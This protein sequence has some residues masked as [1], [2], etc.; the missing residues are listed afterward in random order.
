MVSLRMAMV[1]IGGA[2]RVVL[3]M[4]AVRARGA[5]LCRFAAVCAWLGFVFLVSARTFWLR[6]Q[7]PPE[8]TTAAAQV[9]PS[10]DKRKVGA[11]FVSGR[12]EYDLA[13]LLWSLFFFAAWLCRGGEW[14]T[15]PPPPPRVQC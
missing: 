5:H 13:L 11:D 1:A 4:Q 7:R 2:L 6:T 3:C 8:T 10:F 9:A 12:A 14:T 15:S